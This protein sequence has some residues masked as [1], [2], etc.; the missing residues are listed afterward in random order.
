MAS[1]DTQLERSGHRPSRTRLGGALALA[2][3]LPGVFGVALLVSAWL[4]RPLLAR[5]LKPCEEAKSTPLTVAWGIALLAIAA[6]QMAGA[7]VGFGSIASPTGLAA[8]T[9]FALVAETVLLGLSMGYL[10]RAAREHPH[11]SV[12]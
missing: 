6:V 8:R 11:V 1:S 7:L 2:A 5:A 9:G 3:L 12:P 10:A 4:R